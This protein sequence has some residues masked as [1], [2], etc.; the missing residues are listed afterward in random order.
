MSETT[1]LSPEQLIDLAVYLGRT[2]SADPDFKSEVRPVAGN[3]QTIVFTC[4][5][6]VGRL[7]GKGGQTFQ[8]LRQVISAAAWR[9]GLAFELLL[10]KPC[11]TRQEQVTSERPSTVR[12]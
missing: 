7:I 8:A 5:N 11:G 12:D 2:I 9:T 4:T 3:R 6:G 1:R 10:N